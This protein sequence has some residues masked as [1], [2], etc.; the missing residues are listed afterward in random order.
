LITLT[1][2]APR[3]ARAIADLAAEMDQFYGETRLDPPEAR[4]GQ[5]TETLFGDSP[6]VYVLLARD[7]GK[8]AGFVSYSFLWPAVG[9]TSSLYLK[10]LYVA[11]AARRA[12]VGTLLMRGLFRIAAD[13]ACTRVEWTTDDDNPDA[14]AF[15]AALGTQPATS[16]IFYRIAGED[17]LKA[18]SAHR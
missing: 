6:A 15:Y 11:A 17:L 10:E 12:G 13:R 7:G 5:I 16:K 1:P 9:L 4:L 14:Q 2:A 3:D 18:A 8:L